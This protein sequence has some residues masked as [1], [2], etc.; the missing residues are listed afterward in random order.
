MANELHVELRVDDD[1]EPGVYANL[2][3]VWHSQ[4][5]FTLDFAATLPAQPG[6][7]GNVIQPARVVARV[8]LAPT[9]VFSVLRALNEN[10]TAYE[11]SFGP[12]KEPGA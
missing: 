4:H 10:L 6:A 2:L 12:V 1:T 5:E 7:D 11:S 8:K 3:S 9:V